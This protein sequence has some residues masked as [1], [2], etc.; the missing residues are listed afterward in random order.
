M[1]PVPGERP[2]SSAALLWLFLLANY[3]V[4]VAL[5]AGFV[6]GE[7]LVTPMPA[8]WIAAVWL[9][10]PLFYLLPAFAVAWIGQRVL[11]P[12]GRV[13]AWTPAVAA[14][15]AVQLGL[16]ADRRIHALYGFHLNGFVWNLV[17]TRG[18]I[19]SLG[20]GS[21]TL[22][23]AA[24]L[25][26]LAL[27]A[28]ALL[29]AALARASRAP[30]F[31]RRLRSRTF[32][33]GF[34]TCMAALSVSERLVYAGA[35]LR[36]YGPLLEW[37]GAFPFYLPLR[38]DRLARRIGVPIA[39][40][41]TLRAGLADARLAY[42]RAPLAFRPDAPRWNVV[43]LCAESL[44]ADALDPERMPATW[45]FA[46]GA[47]RFTQQVSAGNGTRMGVFGLFYG[48][49]GPY[50]FKLLDRKRGPVLI[51][52]LLDRGYDVRGFTS[53]KF[54]YPEFDRT[55]FADVPR[56]ALREGGAGP[57]WQR[58]REQVGA[59]L[60]FLAQRD[61]ARPFF[62]YMF[63]ESPHAP[64]EF[65][66]ETAVRTP[67]LDDLD[68][69]TMDLHRD[70]GRIEN[71]YWNA[72]RHLDTQLDRVFV[73]LEAEGLLDS[74]IV[75]VT[76]DHGEEFLEKGRWGHNSE[77]DEE[78]IRVP[79]ALRAP[80]RAPAVV[81]RLTSHLDVPATLL[82]LLGATNPPADYSLGESLLDGPERPYVLVS[83]WSRV[84]YV[85]ADGKATFPM[86][87]QGWFKQIVT[88]RRDAPVPDP[89]AWLRARTPAFGR[90]LSDLA[91]FTRGPELST[92]V[93][94]SGR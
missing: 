61:R 40:A 33:V 1:V 72:V 84:A 94:A 18:G 31:A 55:V 50:W 29:L 34:L 12:L 37:S 7:A 81:D 60:D 69:L 52:A 74:T 22:A 45:R 58:D 80:G 49:P 8:L 57:G 63:F 44:R 15:A 82:G 87:P 32:A 56:T 92:G 20:A 77:F 79:L 3:A 16:L 90:V 66:P 73:A 39:R 48:L 42:P 30:R 86:Q 17:T 43:V 67:Y 70:I 46:E 28:A 9:T 2:A 27:V 35:Q 91:R 76:G 26:A 64:Y 10:Y 4:A 62:L 53:D 23:E 38:V 65:P 6:P 19:E 71:R 41:E 21:G 47:T 25:G 85:D 14:F 54:S 68:Y 11:A 83:D 78:Q 75:V 5:C 36:D 88:D 13:A 51:R 89:G 59:I 24:A 93:G